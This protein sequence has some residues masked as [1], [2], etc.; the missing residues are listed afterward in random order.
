[1]RRF[2]RITSVALS[3]MAL[4]ALTVLPVE[5][6]VVNH[7]VKVGDNYFKPKNLRIAAGDKV[8]FRWVGSAQHDVKV[9]KGPQ[10]FESKLKNKGKF[11]RTIKKPGKYVLYCTI[12]P[13]MQMKMTVGPP[14][15]TTT[16]TT[17]P[18]PPPS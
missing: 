4:G 15:P 7:K 18:A 17:S 13:G 3:V 6:Q 11:A 10:K 16:S 8:T 9:K 12:H 1:V 5:A 2:G 14:P